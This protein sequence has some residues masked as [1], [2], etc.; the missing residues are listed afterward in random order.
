MNKSSTLIGTVRS[1]FEEKQR[2]SEIEEHTT[3]K[4][5]GKNAL[6]MDSLV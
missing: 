2:K 4:L 1:S 5:L 3:E 6:Q